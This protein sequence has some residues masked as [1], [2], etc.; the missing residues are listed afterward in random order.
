MENRQYRKKICDIDTIVD[1]TESRSRNRQN[2]QN[3]QKLTNMAN[4]DKT[5]DK[6]D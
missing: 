3:L 6:I 5:I 4:I 2:L 1:I